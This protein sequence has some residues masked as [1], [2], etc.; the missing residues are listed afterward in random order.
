[1]KTSALKSFFFLL[2]IIISSSATFAQ[3]PREEVLNELFARTGEQYFSFYVN[4][5]MLIHELTRMISVDLVDPTGKVFA[6][7]NKKE[8][9]RFLAY[10]LEYEILRHPGIYEGELNMKDEINIREIREWDFYPTYDAYVDMMY[11]YAEQ[12]PS[13]C[14]VFSIGTTPNGREIIFAR[15]SDNVG[16]NENE[17]QFLYTSSIHGDETTG[18]VLMLRLI[19]YLLSN[20]GTLPKITNLVDQVDIWINPLANP[21]GTYAGG[22]NTVNGAMRYNSNW[23]DLNRNYPDPEDGPHPDGEAWQP[24]TMLFMDLAEDNHFVSG[25][26]LHGGEEVC[27]YPWDTWSRLSADDDWWQYVCREYADT[28]HLYAPSGYMSDFDNGI[29]NGYAWYSISGGRQDYM[30]FFHQCREFTL[31]ISDVKLLPP[32]QLPALW[33]YNY[34]SLLNYMEQSTFGLRGTVK[35][36]VT[37]WP[38]RAEVYAI[39]HE[40]DSSWVYTDMPNGNY[41][42]LL[43]A[44]TYTVRYSAPG[45]ETKV[46]S[47]ISVTNRQATILD[48]LLAPNGV[49]GI[50]N[51]FI[52]LQIEVF[53]NPVTGGYCSFDS[54]I[55]V[56]EVVVSD[57]TGKEQLR[58]DVSNGRENTIELTSLPNGMYFVR[59]ETG[60]GPGLKKILINR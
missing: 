30:N 41:H 2:V 15:I 50:E 39:L 19:D 54:G 58:V 5:R 53:P 36:S 38:V 55:P 6:Y 12:Y 1:M 25:A 51:H 7:A 32:G 45:Y 48:V 23:I 13:L 24:E 46:I 44:G 49:G 42:R 21:D 27:N 18:Y 43:H 34:R 29:T 10:G 33:N 57:I 8:F 60:Q 31:E 47:G 4:D 16:M 14:Q 28:V 56:R 9:S 11:Q 35:D 22:N 3:K 40:L 17:P 59:F 37:G 20:Y 52:S 26:N